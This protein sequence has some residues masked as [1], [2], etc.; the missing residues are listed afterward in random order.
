MKKYLAASFFLISLFMGVFPLNAQEAIGL[1]LKLDDRPGNF[2]LIP[3]AENMVINIFS[4]RKADE[5][6]MLQWH[7]ALYDAGL[8]NIWKKQLPVKEFWKLVDFQ[9]TDSL[10]FLFFS[11][12]IDQNYQELLFFRFNGYTGTHDYALAK[13]EMRSNITLMK[14]LDNNTIFLGGHTRR[15]S[16]QN[17]YHSCSKLAL[18]PLI[19]GLMPTDQQAVLLKLDFENAELQLCKYESAPYGNVRSMELVKSQKKVRFLVEEVHK[20]NQQRLV[21]LTY[22]KSGQQTNRT[23]LESDEKDRNLLSG[24]ISSI[25]AEKQIVI[26]TYNNSGAKAARKAANAFMRSASGLYFA[27]FENGRQRGIYYYNFTDFDNFIK[28][29]NPKMASKVLKRKKRKE[30]QGKELTFEY[31]FLFHDLLQ[32]DNQLIALIEAYY[33]SYHTEYYT[34]IDY[35]GRPV[36]YSREVFDGYQY[37][38]A[39]LAGF[40]LNGKLLWNHSLDMSEIL[41]F[42][43][44]KRIRLMISGDNSLIMVYVHRGKIITKTINQNN[45]VEDTEEIEL[46]EIAIP[47]NVKIIQDDI[48]YWY[49]NYFLTYELKRIKDIKKKNK[50]DYHISVAKIK[51]QP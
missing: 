35:Y 51:Y 1:N 28:G 41:T 33:P 18:I 32:K 31:Q 17:C 21:M 13:P 7:I 38:S 19:V 3:F 43:L 11:R 47:K 24:V 22:E 50:Y 49:Q 44:R 14:A 29:M 37:T 25:N 20:N 39:I 15:S 48:I 46:T 26:G 34:S 2:K 9:I 36:S 23:V 42:D 40:D 6:D 27:S 12:N 5:K 4:E 30:A 16:M 45:I 8:K 10:L